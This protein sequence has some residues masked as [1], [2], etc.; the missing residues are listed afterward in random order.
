M[1]T[2]HKPVS[3]LQ[4]I[5]QISPYACLL[6]YKYFS[7]SCSVICPHNAV[8]VSYCKSTWEICLL[9]QKTEVTLIFFTM[10]GLWD[11][12]KLF[13]RHWVLTKHLRKFCCLVC[14]LLD[15]LCVF[16]SCHGGGLVTWWFLPA[17][18]ATA[19]ALWISAGCERKVSMKMVSS[20]KC[21]CPTLLK[22]SDV[23]Y[24]IKS[25]TRES[26]P[27]FSLSNGV[28]QVK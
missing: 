13:D 15:T 23:A 21:V 19:M 1:K 28:F 16:T 17:L 20:L 11:T 14:K 25:Q 10:Y 9:L 12:V 22:N 18:D 2:V 7:S 4:E 26:G 24:E 27:C 5:L 8:A 3:I 6:K